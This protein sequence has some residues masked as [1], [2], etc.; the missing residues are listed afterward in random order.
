MKLILT[1]HGNTFAPGDKVVWTGKGNDLPLVRKGREQAGA[2]AAAINKKK[3]HLSAVYCST[4]DRTK[5][6]AEIIIKELQLKKRVVIDSRLDEIDYGNWTGLTSE[7]VAEKF[8]QKVLEDWN[9]H[10]IWPTD[11]GWRGSE[12]KTIS[13]VV[14]FTR[15]VISSRQG[16]DTILIISSNGRLRYFLKLIPR[17]FEKRRKNQTYKVNTGHICRLDYHDAILS[18][19]YWNIPPEDIY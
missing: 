16:G 14:T 18:L 9:K 8:G 2:I 5:E 15:D 7:Q 10:S 17:E 12:E 19:V 3:I 6:F 11:S 13:E 4:L 1:R